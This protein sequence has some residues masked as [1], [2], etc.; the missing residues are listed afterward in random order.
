MEEIRS[1]I[2]ILANDI[3]IYKIYQY[4]FHS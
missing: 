2:E 3:N 4:M 1:H